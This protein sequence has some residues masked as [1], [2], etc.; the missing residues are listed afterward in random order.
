MSIDAA[1]GRLGNKSGVCTS[2][3]RPVNPFEGQLIYETDT[4]RTLVYDNAA[5]LVVAD[6]QVLSIDPANGRVGVNDTSPSY[7]LDVTGDINATGNVNSGGVRV[8]YY[9]QYVGAS[10]VLNRDAAISMESGYI[11]FDLQTD[12]VMDEFN[13]HDPSNNPTRITPT[14]SGIYL[15]MGACYYDGVQTGRFITRVYKNGTDQYNRYDT[16][17]TSA[18]DNGGVISYITELNGSTDYIE[19]NL[20]QTTGS[21][22]NI[23]D[24]YLSATLLRRS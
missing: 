19:L 22:I 12:E 10:C 11:S 16:T 5:W 17:L 2:S 13:W 4:N 8:D 15:V 23:R 24:S 6:N 7:A 1:L 9:A 14:I 3:T 21:N 18:N 20:L